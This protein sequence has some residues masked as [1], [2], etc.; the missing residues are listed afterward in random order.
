[1]SR[2]N[3]SRPIIVVRRHGEDDH[4]G[5]SGQWK[6]A[7]ADF[8][9]A[10]MAFFMILWIVTTTTETQ[11]AGIAKFF[12]STATLDLH[13]GDNVLD[14]SISVIGSKGQPEIRRT[15]RRRRAGADGRGDE[16]AATGPKAAAIR[17]EDRTEAQRLAAAKAEIERLMQSGELKDSAGHIAIALLPEGLRL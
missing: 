5:H 2:R 15:A 11:R 6:V 13:S 1:M 9:T 17:A 12:D 10:M 7:Y 8:V 4:D 14:G 3:E 16:F